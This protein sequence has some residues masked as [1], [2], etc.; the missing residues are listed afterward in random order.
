MKI[1]ISESGMNIVTF[2]SIYINYREEMSGNKSN[3]IRILNQSEY[4]K[5]IEIPPSHIRIMLIH[6]DGSEYIFNNF[7]TKRITNITHISTDHIYNT[8]TFLFS[9][10]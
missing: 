10:G 6:K 2:K 3:T 1:H 8:Y 5:F 9:W 7:F 4:D